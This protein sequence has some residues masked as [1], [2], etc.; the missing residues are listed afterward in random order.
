MTAC[1]KSSAKQLSSSSRGPHGIPCM[2]VVAGTFP[3]SLHLGLNDVLARWPQHGRMLPQDGR[4]LDLGSTVYG[5]LPDD[6]MGSHL[7]APRKF[8]IPL[9]ACQHQAQQQMLASSTLASLQVPHSRNAADVGH[10]LTAVALSLTAHRWHDVFGLSG[11]GLGHH[12]TL[13]S[14]SFSLCLGRQPLDRS[15]ATRCH[16]RTHRRRQLPRYSRQRLPPAP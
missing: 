1:A 14:S 15:G 3:E 9:P 5:G 8:V 10:W 12:I 6:W 13:P 16:C 2:H 7:E 4:E 11:L